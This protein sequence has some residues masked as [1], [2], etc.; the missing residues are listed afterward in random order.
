MASSQSDVRSSM[1]SRWAY[2]EKE[3]KKEGEVD[4]E[5]IKGRIPFTTTAYT[6]YR[7]FSLLCLGVGSASEKRGP[8]ILSL[9]L[10]VPYFF[11]FLCSPLGPSNGKDWLSLLAHLYCTVYVRTCPRAQKTHAWTPFWPLPLKPL[12][13]IPSPATP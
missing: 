12:S 6:V 2:L 3:K 5:G 7:I 9:F 10:K 1:H 4:I 13:C 11:F 8:T